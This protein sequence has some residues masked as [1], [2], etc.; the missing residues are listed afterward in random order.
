MGRAR[1]AVIAAGLLAL[2]LAAPRGARAA[3]LRVAV[4]ELR[5]AAGYVHVAL[6][7]APDRFPK[8]DGMLVDKVAKATPKGAQVVFKGVA[9]GTYALAVYHDENGNRRF[10]QGLFGI[11]LEGYAFS[12]GATGFLGPPSFADAAVKVPEGGA[13]ITIPMSYGAGDPDGVPSTV[14]GGSGFGRSGRQPHQAAR[15]S[16]GL[17]GPQVVDPFTDPDGVDR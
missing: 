17:E 5:S 8:D 7:A 15:E 11:P 1:T 2:L 16:A 13:R 9:P 10:D 3:D 4:T 12:N 14:P 6:Y